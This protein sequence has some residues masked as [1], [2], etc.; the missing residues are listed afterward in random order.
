MANVFRPDPGDRLYE[1]NYGH[2][3]KAAARFLTRRDQWWLDD[4]DYIIET[5]IRYSVNLNKFRQVYQ[6]L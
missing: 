2:I 6:M 5:L 3:M 4:L 1:W